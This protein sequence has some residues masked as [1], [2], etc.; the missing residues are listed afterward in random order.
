MSQ[1]KVRP[2]A[3]LM[4]FRILKCLQKIISDAAQL[5][6]FWVWYA[7]K[8]LSHLKDHLKVHSMPV[9]YEDSWRRPFYFPHR[10]LTATAGVGNHLDRLHLQLHFW[11]FDQAAS[12][13][14]FSTWFSTLQVFFDSLL[15]VLTL[16]TIGLF[17]QKIND[18]TLGLVADRVKICS[19]RYDRWSCKICSG[20]V[21]FHEK[22][23]RFFA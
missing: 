12:L 7:K 16:C 17:L 19:D 11:I 3:V 6:V 14:L 23:T 8:Y 9:K 21:N 4:V 5:R 20:C 2:S 15:P 18:Q 22:T 1:G 10:H 13:T